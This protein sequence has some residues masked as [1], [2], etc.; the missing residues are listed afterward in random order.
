MKQATLT[1]AQKRIAKLVVRGSTNREVAATLGLSAKTVEW[2]L[3]RLY[4]QV[5]VRSRTEFAWRFW[6]LRG[7]RETR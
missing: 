7:T 6:R 4:R 3:S 5:G 1:P 2:H